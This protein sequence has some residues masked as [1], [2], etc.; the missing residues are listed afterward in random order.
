MK[1]QVIAC[2]LRAGRPGLANVVAYGQQQFPSDLLRSFRT[3]AKYN[4]GLWKSEKQ[5]N[6]LW[7]WAAG[8]MISKTREA[9]NWAKQT[10]WHDPKDRKQL[11]CQF[12]TVDDRFGKRDPTK[13][14]Y[15]GAYVLIDGTG[16]LAI[17]SVKVQ[18]P[19]AGQELQT[20]VTIPATAKTTFTRDHNVVPPI[21][22][23]P[24]GDEARR[25]AEQVRKNEPIIKAIESIPDWQSQKIFVNFHDILM[26]GGTLSPNMLRVVERNVPLPVMNVGSADD[27]LKKMQELDDWVERNFLPRFTEVMQENDRIAYER[28]LQEHERSPNLWKKPE[29]EDSKARINRAWQEYRA[30]KIETGNESSES[31]VF[32]G[33]MRYA[34]E[35][36]KFNLFR[37]IKGARGASAFDGYPMFRAQVTK[38]VP[39]L[40]RGKA[41]SKT[42]VVWIRAMLAL[43]DK[44]TSANP[45]SIM[46]WAST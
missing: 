45:E 1:R 46:K 29:I 27:V 34:E 4:D 18:H 17:A 14:R 10:G 35:A 15:N 7:K 38:A 16:V 6:F 23:D 11:A 33:L 9:E 30:G 28:D 25:T 22:V 12:V 5:G 20:A 36:L 44:L 8:K 37:H 24:A 43:H 3:I 21:N 2:L 39:K 13:I 31:W 40:K 42:A 41:P 32:S 19:K 26:A